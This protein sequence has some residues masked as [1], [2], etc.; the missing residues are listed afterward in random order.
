MADT[1]YSVK[2]DEELKDRIMNAIKNSGVTGKE[3]F[4]K[5]IESYEA[6]NTGHEDHVK[7]FSELEGHLSR[8]RALYS[9]LIE[10]SKLEVESINSECKKEIEEKEKL[11]QNMTEKY[12][13]LSDELSKIKSAFEESENEKNALKKNLKDLTEKDET[14]LELIKEYKEKIKTIESEIESYKAVKVENASLKTQIAGM[15]KH[16]EEI[17]RENENISSKV[18]SLKSDLERIQLDH[19]KEMEGISVRSNME[20]QTGIMKEKQ[21]CQDRI[22]TI[23][24]DQRKQFEEYNSTIKKLYA[25]IDEMRETILSLKTKSAQDKS[26]GGASN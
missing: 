11:L 4:S 26:N 9:G 20:Y 22:R 14:N 6:Q 13:G 21:E 23:I 19:K 17:T 16:V 1:T 7:E 24:D 15:E 18:E 12:K 3:F 5:L 10:D 25:Q 8:I 2:I